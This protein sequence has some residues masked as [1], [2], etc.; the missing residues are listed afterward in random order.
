MILRITAAVFT[1]IGGH[2]LNRRWDKAILFLCLFVFYL[3][4]IYVILIFSLR[5]ITVS[6]SE[7]SQKI[8]FITQSL[9]IIFSTGIF[10]L[11]L[12]SLII[13]ILDCKNSIE[14][15]IIKWTK[16]GIAGA[17]LTSIMSFAVLAFAV[18]IFFSLSRYYPVQTSSG[19]SP[20]NESEPF[21]F[22]S[23]NFYEYL[24]FGGVPSNSDNLPGPP[25]G[26]GILKGKISYQKNP[27]GSVTLAI[28]LNSKYRAKNIVTDSDGIFIVN[29]PPGTWTIN[30]IQTQSWKNK[31]E[32][33]FTMY[34][35]AEEKLIGNEYNRHAN[36]MDT[37]LSVNVT[38]DP[39]TILIHATINK[40]IQLIWPNQNTKGMKAKIDDTIRWEKYPG[41]SKYYVEIKK[42]RRE[43]NT[44]YYEKVTS[45]IL[46][47]ETS[48]RLSSLKHA[49]TVKN[50]KT[51]YGAEIYAFSEDGT[52]IAEYSDTYQGGTFLLSDGNMLI[53]DKLD[54]LFNL[55]SIED[56]DEFEKKMEAISLNERRATAV[57]VLI[58]EKMLHEAELLLD[59]IDS[60]YSQGK[61]EVLLGYIYALKGKCSKSNEMFD[62]ASFVNPDI[63][64]PD[65]YR[66]NCQ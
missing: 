36:F 41:A 3:A 64:I 20:S 21:D 13:T 2:Y 15:D 28:V 7:A 1:G 53:E 23:Y 29:L 43:G 8:H 33:S 39:K 11:W 48:I 30:S 17:I 35:G 50:K 19:S 25:S 5:T 27:A 32:G 55:S 37:G 65:T 38:T 47:N 16:S 6:P 42:I 49:R 14:A 52:L 56:P 9:W 4:A 60:E 54:D 61:K 44:T 26:K 66:G 59:H 18:N 62:K 63:C 51:E 57:S 10:I 24:Y 58:N 40:D 45:K 31:P 46:F 22:S 12:V 34:S